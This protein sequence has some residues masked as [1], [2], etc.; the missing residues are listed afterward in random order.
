MAERARRRGRTAALLLLGAAALAGWWALRVEA[1][2]RIVR[3]TAT[4]YDDFTYYYPTFEYAFRELRAGRMPWWNPYQ[5]CGSPFF[6][7]AQHL[8]L[9][10][11]SLLFL[12][13][14]APSA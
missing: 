6:A 2:I 5:H 7:T 1:P 4:N 14:P 12:V 13:L 9:Y 3:L 10:P 8:L 11:F